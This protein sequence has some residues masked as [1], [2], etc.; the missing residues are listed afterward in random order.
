[1]PKYFVKAVWEKEF[2]EVDKKVFFSVAADAGTKTLR[3]GQVSDNFKFKSPSLQGYIEP[4]PPP[5]S[6]YIKEHQML[7][8]KWIALGIRE[9]AFSGKRI[10][11]DLIEN[12][13]LWVAVFP[14]AVKPFSL[15]EIAAGEWDISELYIQAG[16]GQHEALKALAECWEP[17]SC[18]WHSGREIWYT[19]F[20]PN[21]SPP[22]LTW[23]K[24]LSGT[25]LLRV[26]WD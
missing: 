5:V 26:G 21:N 9:D 8:L 12:K 7:L 6:P 24:E 22:C 3:E 2:T 15:E 14:M 25:E 4:D 16:P 11:K 10:A 17:T 1:M 18:D 20:G 13:H 19:G 23:D